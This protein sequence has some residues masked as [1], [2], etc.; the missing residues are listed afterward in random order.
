MS[1]LRVKIKVGEHEFE[2]EGS[3]V[4]VER[5]FEAF[6]RLIAPPAGVSE[7][8]PAPPRLAVERIT[9]H[10]G[11]ILSLSEP[12]NAAE[13]VLVIL[14][15]QRL[16]HQ[17]E[18]VSGTEIMAGLRNSGIRINRADYIL[19]KHAAEGA[20]IAIGERR[21]RRYRLSTEGLAKAEAIARRLIAQVN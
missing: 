19:S 3:E 18:F 1:E 10:Q 11:K 4:S 14:L 12:A 5:Q 15:L 16:Y 6:K 2:A 8:E 21:R 9:L 20:I 7:S 13:A 17:L